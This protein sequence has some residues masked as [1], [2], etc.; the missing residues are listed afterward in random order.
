MQ[1]LSRYKTNRLWN[2][3]ANIIL[4]DIVST[5]ATAL[6]IQA[7]Q[8]NLP[9]RLTTVMVTAIVDGAISSP[10]LPGCTPTRTEPAA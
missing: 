5:A 6:I 4:A 2:I 8:P 3:N 9:T 10:C 1:P 7:L